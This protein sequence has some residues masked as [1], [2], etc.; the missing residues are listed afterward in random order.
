MCWPRSLA[1]QR[2]ANIK[3]PVVIHSFLSTAKV[4]LLTNTDNAWHLDSTFHTRPQSPPRDGWLLLPSLCTRGKRG[5]DTRP[6]SQCKPETGRRSPDCFPGTP[7]QSHSQREHTVTTALPG[8]AWA[9]FCT[10]TKLPDPSASEKVLPSQRQ[11]SSIPPTHLH[12]ASLLR[13]GASCSSLS[14]TR[15]LHRRPHPWVR[16]LGR[17]GSFS[18]SS[19][20]A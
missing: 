10:G 5:V 15:G 20:F 17:R 1:A 3:P 9:G 11:P 19:S 18:A 16:A 2:F 8:P 4:F 7:W 12:L 13:S 14:L 6:W